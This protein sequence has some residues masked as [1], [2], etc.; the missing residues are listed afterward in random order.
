MLTDIYQIVI[1]SIVNEPEIVLVIGQNC[2][3][4][5]NDICS[6]SINYSLEKN[7]YCSFNKPYDFSINSIFVIDN[8]DG[9]EYELD[10][11]D[12]IENTLLNSKTE[13]EDWNDELEDDM[14]S[15][16]EELI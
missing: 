11:T 9:S 14:E 2:Y 16:L 10:T 1:D 13:V 7:D 6:V 8:N 5:E 15:D 4:I 12:E 3:Y